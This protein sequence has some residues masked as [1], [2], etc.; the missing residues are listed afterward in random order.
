M[1][2]IALFLWA[3][4]AAVGV[5]QRRRATCGGGGEEGRGSKVAR[6]AGFLAASAAVYLHPTV[7]QFALSLLS[8]IP[9]RVSQSALQALDGG[10]AG[11]GAGASSSPSAAAPLASIDV[12]QTNSFI[13]CFH[14]QVW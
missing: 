3:V 1:M 9:V 13:I 2:A 7:S 6:Q 11:G 8:C 10:G 14:G 4:T 12:L 5:L